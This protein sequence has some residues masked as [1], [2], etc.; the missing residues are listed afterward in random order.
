MQVASEFTANRAVQSPPGAG[1]EQEEISIA[2][3]P[4][5]CTEEF[6]LLRA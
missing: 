4:R 2:E 3:V 1:D 6:T 5:S